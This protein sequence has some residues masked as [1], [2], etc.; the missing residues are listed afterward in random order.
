MEKYGVDSVEE[1]QK[2]EA[3]SLRKRIAELE[4]LEKRAAADDGELTTL[5]ERLAVLP[6]K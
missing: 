3:A 1:I 2:E 4:G 6:E 5:R